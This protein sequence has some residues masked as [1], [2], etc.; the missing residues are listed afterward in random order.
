MS[1]RPYRYNMQLVFH[2]N[3]ASPMLHACRQSFNCLCF[4][5]F[6]PDVISLWRHSLIS[7]GSE[8]GAPLRGLLSSFR[9]LCG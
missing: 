3:Y 7:G 5:L 4:I 8:Q 6:S 9:F 2:H 1:R